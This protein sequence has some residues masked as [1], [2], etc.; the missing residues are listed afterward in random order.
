[1]RELTQ[2]HVRSLSDLRAELGRVLSLLAYAGSSDRSSVERAFAAGAGRIE[3][4]QLALL[5]PDARLLD[6]LWPAIRALRSLAPLECGKVVDACAHTVLADGRVI[7]DEDPLLGAV[8]DALGW[9]LPPLPK[10]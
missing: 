6:G 4:L 2:V 10:A 5:A 9:P 8:C 7:G 3:G 1:A